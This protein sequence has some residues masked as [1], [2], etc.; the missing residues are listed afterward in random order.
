M[1]LQLARLKY[2]DPLS[3]MK[4]TLATSPYARTSKPYTY[5]G[6]GLTQK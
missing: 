6:E 3:F 4:P 1:L 5:E 2:S